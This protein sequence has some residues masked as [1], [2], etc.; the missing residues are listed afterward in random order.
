[1]T[2]T[3]RVLS[4]FLI[5]LFLLLPGCSPA[6]NVSCYAENPSAAVTTLRVVSVLENG[7]LAL[8]HPN[9]YTGMY[10]NS[11]P[12]DQEYRP[13][14]LLRITF[15]GE[16]QLSDPAG[17]IG[18]TDV[19]I[20]DDGFDDRCAL[21]LQ[22]LEDLWQED[23][24]LQADTKYV[25]IDLTNTS[26]SKSEQYAVAWC[27]GCLHQKDPLNATFEQLCDEGYIDKDNLYWEDGCLLSI[28]ET[29]TADRAVTFTAEKWRSGLGAIFF[30]DCTAE[31]DTSGH[32]NDYTPGGFAIS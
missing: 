29:E 20:L 22:V 2:I 24:A 11:M 6:E 18:I 32:W 21:Y 7:S 23:Q 25:G 8:A 3:K 15:S 17:L 31:R 30:T 5:A 1:M 14:M 12:D 19:E 27:F 13:G 28:T 10:W 4:V 26:L 9:E 16:E